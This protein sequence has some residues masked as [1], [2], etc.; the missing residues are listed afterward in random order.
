MFLGSRS[1]KP[2]SALVGGWFSRKTTVDPVEKCQLEEGEEDYY[3]EKDNPADVFLHPWHF[4]DGGLVGM[5][6]TSKTGYDLNLA[7]SR[8]MSSLAKHLSTKSVKGPTL[9]VA[10][11]GCKLQVGSASESGGSPLSIEI[12]LPGTIATS[13]T[14][15]PSISRARTL[16]VILEASGRG[17]GLT[18]SNSS[19]IEF[20]LQLS[21]Q[22]CFVH[23]LQ[24]YIDIQPDCFYREAGGAGR[25]VLGSG[26]YG[27]V[28]LGRMRSGSQALVA[29]KTAKLDAQLE[30][31]RK[32]AYF[33]RQ[34]QGH[35]S[36]IQ[37]YGSF[38]LPEKQGDKTYWQPVI[39]LAYHS[40]G[41]LFDHIYRLGPLDWQ[42]AL[43]KTK[44]LFEALLHIHDRGVFH[45]DVKP[46]N[47]LLTNTGTLVLTDFGSAVSTLDEVGMATGTCTMPYASPEM[48]NRTCTNASG[49]LF[50][51]GV[52]LFFVLSR[53]TPFWAESQE[54]MVRKV[55]ECK[56]LWSTEK[57]DKVS[58]ACKELLKGL[59]TADAKDRL[60]A[61]GALLM[62][63]GALQ[64]CS[65][66]LGGQSPRSKWSAKLLPGKTG[67]LEDE[68]RESFE[69]ILPRERRPQRSKPSSFQLRAMP[70]SESS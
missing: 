35:P 66:S 62:L 49:D 36:I 47:L 6:V 17:W 16:I 30:R 69:A 15:D 5:Q 7:I 39:A 56:V 68:R 31:S 57:L 9:P 19:A 65:V 4:R 12:E 24:K 29:M 27:K 28:S 34:S 14:L 42:P 1:G 3:S 18:C 20:M 11:H 21:P 13:I 55:L 60:S 22:A 54:E 67:V 58:P 48:L 52:T 37:F 25:K 32:E 8:M 53:A 64:S 23:D 2:L 70:L 50:G 38:L 63:S 41:D 59:I 51:A 40:Y 26:S 46:E 10:I 44:D 45:R 33:L 43:T 61:Q